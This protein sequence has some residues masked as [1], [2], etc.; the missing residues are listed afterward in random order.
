MNSLPNEIMAMIF[1]YTRPSFWMLNYTDIDGTQRCIYIA[2]KSTEDILAYLWKNR[3]LGWMQEA[4]Q[5]IETMYNNTFNI[6]F[7][8]QEDFNAIFSPMI[9]P[10]KVNF[11]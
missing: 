10:L 1:S 2:G 7:E 9:N 5:S 4:R 8:I 11:A 6:D 3:H